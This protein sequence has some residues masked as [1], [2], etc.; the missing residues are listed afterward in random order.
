MLIELIMFSAVVMVGIALLVSDPSK[1]VYSIATSMEVMVRAHLTTL[2]CSG[3]GRP[4]AATAR[5]CAIERSAILDFRSPSP[6]DRKIGRS[7]CER[8]FDKHF[9]EAMPKP[10]HA[11]K[12]N[13]SIPTVAFEDVRDKLPAH[14]RRVLS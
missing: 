1:K 8:V 5:R 7:I 2:Q 4:L 9:C 12:E 14:N 3:D 13:Y 10:L 11:P 6:V